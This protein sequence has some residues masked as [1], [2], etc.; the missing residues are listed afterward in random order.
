[1]GSDSDRADPS[2]MEFLGE[3]CMAM[4]AADADIDELAVDGAVVDGSPLWAVPDDDAAAL[5]AGITA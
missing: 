3:S 4:G 2:E 5:D 1:L